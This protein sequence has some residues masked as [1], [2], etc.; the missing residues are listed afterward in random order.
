MDEHHGPG[1]TYNVHVDACAQPLRQGNEYC[2][3]RT[4]HEARIP[5]IGVDVSDSWPNR[6]LAGQTVQFHRM[7]ASS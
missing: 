2:K 3:A 7:R 5:D 6:Q 4:R 1:V